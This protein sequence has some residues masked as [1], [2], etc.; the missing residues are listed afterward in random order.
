MFYIIAIIL[1][2]TFLF[3]LY[4]ELNPQITNIW[5]RIGDDGEKHIQ[6]TNLI[7]YMI[8]PLTNKE[9]WNI[10]LLDCNYLFGII[11]IIIVYFINI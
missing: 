7:H 5:Y 3:A 9:L 1:L 2:Y 4:L 6:L 10:S 11:I 8:A